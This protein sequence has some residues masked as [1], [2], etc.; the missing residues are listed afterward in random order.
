MPV[1]NR[2]RRKGFLQL[3][4]LVLFI[5]LS[6][7]YAQRYSP[8][9]PAAEDLELKDL[10]LSGWDCLDKPEGLAKT[11]DGKERNPQKNRAP[12]DLAGKE[13]PAM[14]IAGFLK[15]VAEYDV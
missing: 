5:V 4:G 11:P 15:R 14:D 2:R 10:D 1:E 12:I 13:I 9:P 8:T 6:S 7:I 3:S